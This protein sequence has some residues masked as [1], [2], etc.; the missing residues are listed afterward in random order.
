MKIYFYILLVTLFLTNLTFSQEVWINE[1]SYTCADSTDELKQGDEFIEIVAP[2]GTN[3]DQYG[4]VF[5]FYS[6]DAYHAYHYSQL[7]GQISSVN[8]NYGRGLFLVKTNLS[9]RLENNNPID[10]GIVRQALDSYLE[11]EMTPA[12]ILLVEAATGTAIHGVVYE[13]SNGFPEPNEILTEKYVEIP[14]NITLTDKAFDIIRLPLSDSPLSGPNGSI[15]MIGSGF[16]RFWTTTSGLARN[17]CTPGK[18][19]YNQSALPVE[20]SIFSASVTNKNV[21]LRWRTETETNNFGFEI[22]RKSSKES[23]SMLGF[24]NGYGNSN[25]P[26]E[27][28]YLDNS[29]KEGKYSYRLRQI[30]ND[31]NFTYSKTLEVDLS[32]NFEYSLSQNFPNP[33]NPATSISFTLPQSGLVKLSVYNLLGQEVKTIHN[34]ILEAGVH[35]YN[36]DAKDLNSCID[37]YKI[38]TDNYTQ[39]RKMTLLK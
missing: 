28:S 9:Y 11:D 25:S 36:F 18:I 33:F 23:W 20:L 13:I 7:N 5:F 32:V 8:S 30:D 22:E 21:N 34:G 6:D 31:G 27:Y 3:M 10:A 14:W 37:I 38:V 4:I 26:K 35:T 1:F 24:I 39:T 12:G 2:V 17:L 29:V 16:S 19:N 15:S